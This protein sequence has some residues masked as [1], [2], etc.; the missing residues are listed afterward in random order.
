MVKERNSNID[1]YKKKKP[2]EKVLKM[3]HV[4]SFII[5]Y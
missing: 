2:K 4:K 5:A 1:S 3:L